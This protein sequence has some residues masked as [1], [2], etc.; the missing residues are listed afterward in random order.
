MLSVD[1]NM[2]GFLEGRQVDSPGALRGSHS[3]GS[4]ISAAP[5]LF[6]CTPRCC[7][8]SVPLVTASRVTP[9]SWDVCIERDGELS[10]SEW[11][12]VC[13]CVLCGN[14]QRHV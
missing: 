8:R 5:H 2:A 3:Q 14:K 12:V 10:A 7:W 11:C 9:P 4:S 13:L 1:M 6:F